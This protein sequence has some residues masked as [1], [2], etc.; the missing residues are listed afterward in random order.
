MH[1][2]RVWAEQGGV[3]GHPQAEAPAAEAQAYRDMALPAAWP[4]AVEQPWRRLAEGLVASLL[5]PL[6]LLD[7]ADECQSI[8]RVTKLICLDGNSK[9]SK[10]RM[11]A[12]RTQ[13]WYSTIL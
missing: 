11:I 8:H 13:W 9:K 7:S 12:E 10:F 4:R 1:R 2:R 5:V 3:A 6:D